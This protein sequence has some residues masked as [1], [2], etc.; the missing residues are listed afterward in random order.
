MYDKS[1]KFEIY[2]EKIQTINQF[3]RKVDI[4]AQL[5]KLNTRLKQKLK[6]IQDI[7]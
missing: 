1:I 5:R 6:Q 2:Y 4:F 3:F 7:K